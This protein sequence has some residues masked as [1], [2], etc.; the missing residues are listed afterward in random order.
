M[1]NAE[2]R[3]GR[4]GASRWALLVV[5]TSA[6]VACAIPGRL[7]QVAPV[8]SGTLQLD[9]PA[10][11]DATL[12]LRIRHRESPNLHHRSDTTL[13]PD[14]SFAFPAV[15][16]A[17]AGHEYSKFYRAYLHLKVGA[18]D[19]VVWRAEFSRREIRGAIELACD[20][21]RD[22]P[23]G[24]PCQV[25]DPLTHPWLIASGQRTFAELCAGCHGSDGRG[26]QASELPS[27]QQPPDLRTIAARRSGR[28]DPMEIAQWIEGRSLPPAHG[29]RSMPIWGERLSQR[30][31]RYVEGDTLVGVTLD[32]VIVFLQSLQR[33]PALAAPL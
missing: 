7:Y 22:A 9:T 2:R 23:L 17:I 31:E 16:L 3:E 6:L 10:R 29:T 8:V 12:S 1:R 28:F 26:G 19:R 20:L 15:E 14:G 18:E 13:A 27:G 21:E 25:T 33:D 5:G 11:E 4:P 32:P 24:Q 30:F